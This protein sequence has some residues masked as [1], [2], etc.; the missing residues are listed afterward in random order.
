MIGY[1]AL[2]CAI[3]IEVGGTLALRMASTGRR[4]WWLLV[5]ANYGA[6]FTLLSV[7]LG[8]GVPLTVAYGVWTACGVALTA[9][10]SRVLF[11]ERL[12]WIMAT[13]IVLIAAGVLCIELGHPV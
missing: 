8:V 2:A 9:V 4:A 6:A 7:A 11:K 12:T 1:F 10:L 5:I 13:G 3:V